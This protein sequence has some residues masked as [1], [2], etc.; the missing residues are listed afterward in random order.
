MDLRVNLFIVTGNCFPP[1]W[2][3]WAI[4]ICLFELLLESEPVDG[5]FYCRRLVLLHC[6]FC[7]YKWFVQ[8]WMWVKLSGWGPSKKLIILVV[9]YN[10]ENGEIGADLPVVFFL[11]E[12][13]HW[14]LW[15]NCWVNCHWKTI[16]QLRIK[17]AV[18]YWD[19]LATTACHWGS[20][21]FPSVRCQ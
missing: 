9:K 21:H 3:A 8:I 7:L 5:P 11:F 4:F 14:L 19:L 13:V 2:W 16:V 15:I 1:V 18:F 17:I 20:L 10:G 12:N 6:N